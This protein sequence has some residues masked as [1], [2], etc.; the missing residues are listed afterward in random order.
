MRRTTPV[1]SEAEVLSLTADELS[2][3]ENALVID[4][5][6][7]STL[8]LMLAVSDESEAYPHI[9][10]LDE[11]L[12]A[13]VEHR[14]Y[15]SCGPGPA[16]IK[17]A[18]GVY[19]HP[20]TGERAVNQLEIDMPPGH[21]KSFMVSHHLPAWYLI[22]FPDRKVGLAT[23][24]ADFAREWGG[25]VQQ[26]IKEHP[27]YGIEI[28]RKHEAQ[29]RWLLK[30]RRGGMFTAGV[31]GPFTGKRIH[32]GVV[33]DPVKNSEDALSETKRTTNKNWWK[34]TF[35]T[36]AHP[37]G[38]TVYVIMATRW[39]EDDL[40]GHI[41][42]NESERT[43]Q[44]SLP[45]IAFDTVDEEGYSTDPETGT[46]DPLNRRPGEALAPE[47]WSIEALEDFRRIQGPVWFEAMYQGKPSIAA[48][49]K[50]NRFEAKWSLKDGIYTLE[51]PDGRVQTIRENQCLRVAAIDLAATENTDS[52][53]SVFAVGDVT[54]DHYLI[55]RYV[56]RERVT[57]DKHTQWF[58]MLYDSW[59]PRYCMTEQKTYELTLVQNLRRLGRYVMRKATSRGDKV[60]KAFPAVERFG[61]DRVFTPKVAEWLDVWVREHKAFPNAKHDD[62]VDTSWMLV[63]AFDVLSVWAPHAPQDD[64]LSAR[65]DRY[66]D[67]QGDEKHDH[68]E[69]GFQY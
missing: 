39:H 63:E 4:E 3:Y 51:H 49:N 27:E 67:G 15:K 43:Y 45:A 8:S 23:Y 25:K 19:V 11:I 31:G 52:D 20:I 47:M 48:G 36:R 5:Q 12:L 46:R 69:L 32:L 24:E 21:G 42:E 66:V 2:E 7:S 37:D 6:L 64:S 50:F 30:G 57:S 60:A 17:I 29:D 53:W 44:L 14:L 28:D 40:S 18:K 33:D 13:L 35:R 10:L 16:S 62:Q 34:T 9:K 54:P 55:V 59:K 61:E 22:N 41:L 1:L 56:R 38:E 68:P 26:L 65:I 58:T